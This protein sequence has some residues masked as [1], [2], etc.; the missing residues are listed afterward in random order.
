MAE[1][2]QISYLS[3]RVTG[4]SSEGHCFTYRGIARHPDTGNL[5]DVY[6]KL[7]DPVVESKGI[8]NEL[9]SFYVGSHFKFPIANTFICACKGAHLTG[10]LPSW[11]QNYDKEQYYRGIASVNVKSSDFR[12]LR[13][14]PPLFVADLLRFKLLPEL[15]AFDEVIMNP[16]RTIQ[17]LIRTS[18]NHYTL[19]DH[20]QAFGSPAWEIEELEKMANS[21][22][23]NGLASL[24]F[25]SPDEL[26]K[27]RTI[28]IVNGFKDIYKLSVSNIPNNLEE[29]CNLQ[30]GSTKFLVHL[31]NERIKILPQLLHRHEV[32]GQL[33]VD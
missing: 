27:A 16:D 29:I 23:G 1:F 31:V 2:G 7:F 32:V 12:Q 26:L 9:F 30:A 6:F 11:M 17:N 4:T 13:G 18:E 24:V 33:F 20:E 5:V 19:I 3:E 28:K 22:V 8:Y 10:P 15:V 21:V 25:E 14:N